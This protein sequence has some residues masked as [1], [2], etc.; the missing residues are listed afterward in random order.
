[1]ICVNTTLL[2]H[3]VKLLCLLCL[4]TE[5]IVNK[6]ANYKIL[7]VLDQNTVEYRIPF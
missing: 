1:M 6:N 4:L 3:V 7:A 2:F 5:H